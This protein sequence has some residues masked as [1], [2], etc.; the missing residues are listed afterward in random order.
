MDIHSIELKHSIVEGLGQVIDPET[1]VD[2]M[3]CPYCGTGR[4][5]RTAVGIA[6]GVPP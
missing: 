5:I 4:L 1:G 3:R 2:V 6:A